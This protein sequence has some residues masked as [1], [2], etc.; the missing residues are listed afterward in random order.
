MCVRPAAVVL[1]ALTAA[2]AVQHYEPAPLDSAAAEAAFNAR[3]LTDPGLA[4]F[5]A[6]S[7]G[8]TVA[9]PPEE[10]DLRT[11][12][13][14]ALYFNPRL[15]EAR[16]AL[17]E[18]HAAVAS[19]GARPNPTLSLSPGVPSPYLLTLDL[20]FP[21]ETAGKRGYRIEAA[22]SLER[23]SQL[24]LAQAAWTVRVAVRVA[25]VDYVVSRQA[26]ELARSEAQVRETQVK[27]LEQMLSAGEA[28]RLEVDAARSELSRAH[29]VLRGAEEE[30]AGAGAKLA[31]A[32][33]V[34][35]AALHDVRVAWP[36]M[37]A[38]PSASSLPIADI[39]R[40]T[41]INR[42]EVRGALAQYAATEA[43]LKLEIAK[44]YPDLDIGPGYSYEERQ[45]YFTIGL[46]ATLPL[47]NR[48]QGP[49]AE[50]EARR[51]KAA[52]QFIE[53]QS[54]AISRSTEALAVYTVSLDGLKEAER[55][56]QL[57]ERQRL[58]AEESLRVGEADRLELA[59]AEIQY[60]IA[61]RAR[62]DAVAHAQHALGELEQ[63]VERPLAPGEEFPTVDVDAPPR[64][65]AGR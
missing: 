59:D 57:E 56:A 10:W 44:Q 5:T 54:Q 37:S 19:A 14:A 18:A 42:L 25:L 24:E 51:R 58:A 40:D 6:N 20:S 11:L 2:C 62:L 60:S 3:S 64:A 32:I 34:P 29:S 43:A 7:L 36:E 33:G 21:L 38:P 4:A 46:S 48:N 27:I 30:D 26:L 45:S 1:T 23:A 47:L 9:G 35:P 61:A 13:L 28:R 22:R 31:A 55:L 65:A 53:T 50:A 52:A 49:I 15:D 17:A 63:A 16:A 8:Q 12:S 41:V 39:Q